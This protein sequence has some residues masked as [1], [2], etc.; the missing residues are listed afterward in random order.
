VVGRFLAFAACQRDDTDRAICDA[1]YR[2]FVRAC[3]QLDATQRQLQATEDARQRVCFARDRALERIAKIDEATRHYQNGGSDAH[4]AL[5][6][7]SDG[8]TDPY[9]DSLPRCPECGS[10]NYNGTEAVCLACSNRAW[11]DR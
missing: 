10:S 3:D 9:V 4:T 7:I 2:A 6:R 8:S 1:F 11:S 5:C